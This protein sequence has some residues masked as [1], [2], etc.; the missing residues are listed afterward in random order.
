MKFTRIAAAVAVGAMLTACSGQGGSLSTQSQGAGQAVPFAGATAGRS[1]A[2]INHWVPRYVQMKPH[3]IDYAFLKTRQA[4]GTTIPFFTGSV[5]SPLDG[6]TYQYSLVG[7]DPTK[8]NTTTQVSFVPIILVI[9]FA[10]GTVLDPTQPGCNDSLSVANRF[11]QGP[12]FVATPLTSN[13]VNVGRTQVND[14]FQRAEFWTI[15]KGHN[16]HTALVPATSPIVVNVNAPRGSKTVGGVCSGTGHRIGEINFFKYDSIVTNLA[17]TYATTTQVPVILS[18]NTFETFGGCCI[19]GYHNAFARPV[20]AAIGTQVYAV[21]AYNDPGIFGTTPIEDIHAWTHEIGEL[22]NDP[23]INN[24][25]PAWGHVGQV[26]GCQN[27][28]EVGDPLTGTA[29]TLN[30]NGFTYHPQELAFFDWFFRT[31]SSGTG[32]KFSFE[33]T[34]TSSQGACH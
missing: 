14:A 2:D 1:I 27:N 16:Y 8:S 12:N 24:A 6:N 25:T 4:A 18:Y 7:R 9:T 19:L 28:L 20:G 3:G 5:M 22:L 21:G 23:F 13:G 30:Y 10:D 29:F 31:P 17:T 34:F 15:L 11:F 33:G 32:G 26:G